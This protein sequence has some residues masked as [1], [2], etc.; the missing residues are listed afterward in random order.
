MQK[1]LGDNDILMYSTHNEGNSV[2]VDTSN[3][4]AE[5]HFIAFKAGVDKLDIEKLVNASTG[6]NN[7][8]RE[9]DDLD[10]GKLKTISLDL[11]KLTNAASKEVVKNTKLNKLNR[12]VNKENS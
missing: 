3:L 5:S 11:K 6:L 7:F 9:V 2:V 10:V 1:W 12:K 4:A 8:K